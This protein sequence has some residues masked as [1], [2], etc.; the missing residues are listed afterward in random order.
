MTDDDSPNVACYK[1][2]YD[3]GFKLGRAEGVRE[4]VAKLKEAWVNTNGKYDVNKAIAALEGVKG[5][6]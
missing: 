3:V 2:G 1:L 4:C 6:I 5:E